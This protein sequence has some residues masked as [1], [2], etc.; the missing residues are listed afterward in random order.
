MHL[1]PRNKVVP[2][3]D[4]SFP[5]EEKPRPKTTRIKTAKTL[6]V[7]S[8]KIPRREMVGEMI[9]KVVRHMGPINPMG[10][11]ENNIE[12]REMYQGLKK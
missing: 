7:K 1:L 6:G 3:I 9:V 2:C 4:F 5:E 10:S 11:T 8:I 12:S